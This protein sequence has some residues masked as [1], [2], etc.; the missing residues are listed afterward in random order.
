MSRPRKVNSLVKAELM[1][2]GPPFPTNLRAKGAAARGLAFQRQ[3][4]R[5]I[6]DK[7][8]NSGT[9]HEGPW[10]RYY[11]R[12]GSFWC[13]PDLVV[14][15][16]NRAIIIEAKLSLR[17]LSTALKQLNGLYRPCV[18]FIFGLPVV[19]CVA[20]RHWVPEADDGT[21]SMVDEPADLLWLGFLKG[22]GPFGW[23]LL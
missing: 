12:D 11:D 5:T 9:V 8:Q 18:E 1:P 4:A 17:R 16:A 22:P 7:L 3:V 14:A 21:L 2:E 23:H 20:F 6:Q 13:Q 19:Q 10:I 15:T